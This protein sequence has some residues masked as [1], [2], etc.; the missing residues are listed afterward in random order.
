MEGFAW[1]YSP[2]T[3]AIS[4]SWAEQIFVFSSRGSHVLDRGQIL[5]LRTVDFVKVWLMTFQV[6]NLDQRLLTRKRRRVSACILDNMLSSNYFLKIIF[7][8]HYLRYG[9]CLSAEF[10]N[11][12]FPL[13]ALSKEP[14]TAAIT[15]REL[16]I[17]SSRITS[18]NLVLE[19]EV[20]YAIGKVRLVVQNLTSKV[21]VLAEGI[22]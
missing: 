19:D 9:I 17:N 5:A 16:Y 14:L 1:I 2:N 10:H 12:W 6:F 20:A 11:M 13:Q 22:V 7:S 3:C 15:N 21:G 4:R 8:N 18:S